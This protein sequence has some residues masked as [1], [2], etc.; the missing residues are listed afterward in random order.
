MQAV[1]QPFDRPERDVALTALET[2]DEGPVDS[3]DVGELLLTEP[4]SLS[5]GA[6]TLPELA[7]QVAFHGTHAAQWL[8]IDLQTDT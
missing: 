1:G 4:A 5:M 2:T 6:E 3:G 7:L 8:P